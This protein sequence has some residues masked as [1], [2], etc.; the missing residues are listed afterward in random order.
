L[1]L[2]PVM[3]SIPKHGGV[4]RKL[5]APKNLLLIQQRDWR[6]LIFRLWIVLNN[7]HGV[8]S[9]ARCLRHCIWGLS[10]CRRAGCDGNCGSVAKYYWR[11]A[12]NITFGGLACNVL[13]DGCGSSGVIYGAN[14][15]T[16]PTSRIVSKHQHIYSHDAV[17]T[18]LHL[19]VTLEIGARP[20]ADKEESCLFLPIFL[21]MQPL[22]RFRHCRR[23]TGNL[24][25]FR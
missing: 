10:F 24:V 25:E 20:L 7:F 22:V 21:T 9:A 11:N 5:A 18:G 16:S 13:P 6:H 2:S 8:P 3:L 23:Q 14:S 15:S 4:K 19:P 17:V 1:N 12:F